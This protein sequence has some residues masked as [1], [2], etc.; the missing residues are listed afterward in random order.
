MIIIITFQISAVIRCSSRKFLPKA[1]FSDPRCLSVVFS[2]LV[3]LYSLKSTSQ[4]VINCWHVIKILSEN[5]FHNDHSLLV[6]S[7]LNHCIVQKRCKQFPSCYSL[8]RQQDA[9]QKDYFCWSESVPFRGILFLYCTVQE[10][11]KQR[12]SCCNFLRRHN[13][14]PRKYFSW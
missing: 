12:P 11:D 3:I 14:P 4:V 6:E 7:F 9:P 13:A 1:F 2:R 8:L 10:L 5:L